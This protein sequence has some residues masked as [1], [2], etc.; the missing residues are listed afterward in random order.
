M[1]LLLYQL[2]IYNILNPLLSFNK[3]HCIFT[4]SRLHLKTPL[5]LLIHKKQLLS[6]KV[7]S[8]DCNNLVT[9]PG[10]TF[11][12]SSLAVSAVIPPNKS[13]IPQSHPWGVESTS[14]KLLLVDILTSPHESWMFL[15]TARMVNPFQK[16]F[17]LLCPDPSEES[18]Y[19][20][21]IALQNVLLK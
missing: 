21:T 9:S 6:I 4:R 5:Y 20:T 19:I 11:V 10:C 17:N 13:W 15:M 1:L 12:S 16:V 7:F 14:F 3:H 18:Q 8:W 2:S